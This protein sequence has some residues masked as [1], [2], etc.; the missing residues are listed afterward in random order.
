MILH[1]QAPFLTQLRESHLHEMS[2][3]PVAP[4]RANIHPEW[5]RLFWFHHIFEVT[6]FSLWLSPSPNWWSPPAVFTSSLFTSPHNQAS[7]STAWYKLFS[8]Q[9]SP[10]TASWPFFLSQFF[11][12]FLQHLESLLLLGVKST[13]GFISAFSEITLCI[14]SG[15]SR[16]PTTCQAPFEGEHQN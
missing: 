6:T 10:M 3:Y 7:N 9:R 8:Y 1:G 11:L 13:L 15:I 16:A 4:K 14:Q 5:L 2:W 12:T